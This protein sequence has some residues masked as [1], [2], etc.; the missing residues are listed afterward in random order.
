MILGNKTD[1]VVMQVSEQWFNTV[2]SEDR[3]RLCDLR[4]VQMMKEE[5]DV[6]GEA[7]LKNKRGWAIDTS[8]R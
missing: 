6:G 5:Q 4:H 1:I 2:A 3:K 8:F 7:E